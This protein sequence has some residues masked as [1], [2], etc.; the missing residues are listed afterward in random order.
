MIQIV[1]L[2]ASLLA[3]DDKGQSLY[4]F[5]TGTTWT[6]DVKTTGEV[7]KLAKMEFKVT[8]EADGK[9]E[10]ETRA[11]RE[12]GEPRVETLQWSV[13]GG[14]F[15]VWTEVRKGSTR[16]PMHLLK[17]GAKKGDVWEWKDEDRN[18][19]GTHLGVEELKVPA[20]TYK[21]A[22]RVKIEITDGPGTYALDFH[23]VPGIGVVR[24]SGGAGA[25]TITM[26]LKE[27]KPAK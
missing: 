12:E 5:K 14:G 10:V 27:F 2:A 23:L 16:D 17:L 3:Q 25:N 24:M 11:F 15:L 4:K 20:G 18:R 21:D 22:T 13:N 26:E 7:P 9:V 19:K 8:G 1:L 6:F